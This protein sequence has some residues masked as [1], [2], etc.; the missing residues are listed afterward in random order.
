MR[1]S[2]TPSLPSATASALQTM[3]FEAMS[4]AEITAA[5]EEIRKLRLPLDLRRTRRTRPAPHGTRIDM[6]ATLRAGLRHGG[7]LVDFAYTQHTVRPPP[8]VVLCDI[9]GSMARYAQILLH[10]LPRRVRMTGIGSACS[11]SARG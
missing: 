8:L 3:D 10:F 11:C 9:S 2:W 5:R 6:A 1:R 7:E 4:A